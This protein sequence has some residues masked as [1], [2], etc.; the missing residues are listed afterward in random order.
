MDTLVRQ[1]FLHG[2]SLCHLNRAHSGCS[3]SIQDTWSRTAMRMQSPPCLARLSGRE[4]TGIGKLHEGKKRMVCP[5]ECLASRCDRAHHTSPM[6][7]DELW[8]QD[9]AANV[10]SM[11]AASMEAEHQASLTTADRK[12]DRVVIMQASSQNPE[13]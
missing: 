3:Q 6:S 7:L 11:I 1:S 2:V 5:C 10:Y 9:L 4:V 13:F 8:D 12:H